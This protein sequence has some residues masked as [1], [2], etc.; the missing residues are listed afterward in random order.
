[1]FEFNIS[2]ETLSLLRRIEQIPKFSTYFSLSIPKTVA[3]TLDRHRKLEALINTYC[4]DIYLPDALTAIIDWFRMKYNLPP[5]KQT[6]EDFL[7]H[8]MG[9]AKQI[10]KLKKS[11]APY[12]YEEILARASESQFIIVE[13][14][15]SIITWY[16]YKDI[17][18]INHGS[19]FGFTA[20]ATLDGFISE[21]L[22]YM[23]GYHP[24]AY[25]ME[26]KA[27]IGFCLLQKEK[28]GVTLIY[29]DDEVRKA[30]EQSD[31]RS[32]IVME[33]ANISYDLP[34]ELKLIQ[35]YN[36]SETLRNRMKILDPDL[37]NVYIKGDL[38]KTT[39]FIRS[40]YESTVL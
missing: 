35:E 17:N 1:M 34:Y 15:N 24:A 29:T 26:G 30:K 36:E 38:E 33:Y 12:L 4:I 37:W 27:W 22:A 8:G 20:L 21:Y 9:T 13:R 5:K 11:V 28:R 40:R 16:N 3:L 23:K 31:R 14:I 32:K 7:L 39:A 2:E 25:G 19:S 6:L 10:L 18:L